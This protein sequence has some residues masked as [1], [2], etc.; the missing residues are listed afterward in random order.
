MG[1]VGDSCFCFFCL[2]NALFNCLMVKIGEQIVV[3]KTISFLLKWT[4]F[5][6]HARFFAGVIT[7]CVC[8]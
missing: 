5:K 7:N 6:G 4:L 1:A 2:R 3:A 8:K